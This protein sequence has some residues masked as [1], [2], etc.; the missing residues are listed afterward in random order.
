MF[1]PVHVHDRSREN[2]D[3]NHR[4]RKARSVLERSRTR[5]DYIF[6]GLVLVLWNNYSGFSST[7]LLRIAHLSSLLQHVLH[8][9]K[10]FWGLS[11]V[12]VSHTSSHKYACK[13]IPEKLFCEL[14][15]WPGIF[16]QGTPHATTWPSAAPPVSLVSVVG[17]SKAWLWPHGQSVAFGSISAVHQHTSTLAA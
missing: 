13:N 11:P 9:K 4:I 16:N 2:D 7:C 5:S 10:I 17:W 6:Q 15:V 1:Q 12:S 14:T 8:L 3:R